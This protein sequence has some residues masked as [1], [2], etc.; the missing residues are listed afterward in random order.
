MITEIEFND[1]K[2]NAT[3][4]NCSFSDY[5][6]REGITQIGFVP[7]EYVNELE[8]AGFAVYSDWIDFFNNDIASTSTNFKDY[9]NI[10]FLQ[11]SEHSYIKE[12]VIMCANLSRGFTAEKEEWFIDWQRDNDI[13]IIKAENILIG[14]CCVSIYDDGNI[15]W[16]RRISVKP[17]YQGRGYGKTLLEQAIVYG[18]NKGAK[19]GFLAV[20]VLNENAIS[21]YKNYGFVP[22][23]E[24][25]EIT[26]KKLNIRTK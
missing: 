20:D 15:M 23:S 3:K 8:S 22:Q 7:S 12:M 5:C 24:T 17:E 10:L 18:V 9:N 4:L 21:L 25:G 1:L 2:E 11:S 19:R 6:K 26:M 14:Y 16:V 13:I